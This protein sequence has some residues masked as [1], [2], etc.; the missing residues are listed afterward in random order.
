MLGDL[1]SLERLDLY[2]TRIGNLA[3]LGGLKSLRLLRIGNCFCVSDLTPL[4]GLSALRTL[5]IHDTD[6]TDLVPLFRLSGLSS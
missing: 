2:G 6:V 3:P 4:S 1:A 5:Y